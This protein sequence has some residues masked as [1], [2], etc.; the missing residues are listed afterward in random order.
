MRCLVLFACC[1]LFA[2][3][4]SAAPPPESRRFSDHE[5]REGLRDRGLTELLEP[6]I[7]AY[8][9]DNP[10]ET[11]L[12]NY[13]LR[14]RE[15]RDAER[16]EDARRTAL[17]DAQRELE[18]L[19]QRGVGDERRFGWMMELGR[20]LVYDVGEPIS[21]RILYRGGTA[22]DRSELL[23]A[24]QR[25]IDVLSDLGKA[26]EAEYARLDQLSVR[27]Y[28]RLERTGHIERVE[29]FGPQA[30]YVTAWARYYSA[31]ALEP[32]SPARAEHLKQV[33]EYLTQRSGLLD[34]PHETTHAQA[35]A[36]LL[37]GLSRRLIG[38]LPNALS[39]VNQC[40][41]T[42]N[43]LTDEGAR[44]SL[45]WAAILAGLERV[46]VL[47]DMGEFAKALVALQDFRTQFVTSSSADPASLSLELTA[48]LL[49]GSI[50]DTQAAA[51]RSAADRASS[52]AQHRTALAAVAAQSERHRQEVYALLY[53]LARDAALAKPGEVKLDGLPPLDQCA[54]VA[55]LLGE[56][57]S[58][59]A[60][61]GQT[62][63]PSAA[64]R[65]ELRR[66][67]TIA[68]KLL[69][70]PKLDDQLAADVSY[71]LAVAH[72]HLGQSVEAARRFLD[73]A[74]AYPKSDRA[75]RAANL[76]VQLA[77]QEYHREAPA[78]A[79]AEARDDLAKLYLDA[80]NLL[81]TRYPTSASA[82]YWKFFLAKELEASGRYAD[83]A[84]RFDEIAPSHEH[85]LEARFHLAQSRAFELSQSVEAPA[86][87]PDAA[88][89]KRRVDE[90]TQLLQ[91]FVGKA[92]T[93]V[94]AA[95]A[96]TEPADLAARRQAAR[97]LLP[98][99]EVLSAEVQTLPG[100]DRSAEA[101]Q[102]LEGFEKRHGDSNAYTARV[103]RARLTAYQR[104]GRLNEA[105][106]TIEKYVAA[107]PNAAGSTLQRLYERTVGEL[108]RA[109]APASKPAS[110]GA[111]SAL[112][113]A[114]ALAEW[115]ARPDVTV[116]AENRYA[117]AVQLGE[118][119]LRAGRTE[120]ARRQFEECLKADAK[121]SADG[122]PQDARA[123]YGHAETAFRAG[124]FESAL[125]GFHAAYEA[126]PENDPIWWQAL[127]R[128]LQCRTKLNDD[129]R[130]VI[131]VIRQKRTLY[132]ELGGETMR[133]ELDAVFDENQRRQKP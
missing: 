40:L 14:M 83:A 47:T 131:K 54:L 78:R 9:P 69:S 99:A 113:L 57:E 87:R 21:L 42:L 77:S 117:F 96:E 7:A 45:R 19:I 35:Q 13:D 51:G 70:D 25:A 5:F 103:M 17:R 4:A 2:D 90:A 112:L 88:Q 89:L 52:P 20:S 109:A 60:R 93:L 114:R 129:P 34:A 63:A 67:I 10:T 48:A 73:T 82:E 49:D 41:A 132:P 122:K 123:L 46:R 32:R 53:P 6:F 38:D 11:A 94:D 111:E 33:I 92:R 66:V 56:A 31:L 59:L 36:L 95:P 91:D 28:E 105:A 84:R 104:L 86:G 115:A 43:R 76:A 72:H 8:P 124:G 80:L 26:I 24:M 107:D 118:A 68:Q 121:R 16:A 3:S 106:G 23:P 120:E 125:P 133:R 75:E 27:D 79:A 97:K 12:I 39:N 62:G 128:E 110:G 50:R 126:A 18:T 127:L 85:Y 30:E 58:K 55:G 119:L 81:I 15:F 65:D 71:H 74:K 102:A 116:D 64:I 108:D 22:A 44:R 29:G 100:V 130:N 1:C 98:V 61:Q 37:A 101:L